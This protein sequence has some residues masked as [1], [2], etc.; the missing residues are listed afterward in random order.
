MAVV[1]GVPK[2]DLRFTYR[3][4]DDYTRLSTATARKV[5]ATIGMLREQGARHPSLHTRKVAGNPDDR[6]HFMNVDDQYRMVAVLQEP[7]VLLHLVGNHDDTLARGAKAT[8]REFEERLSEDP[9]SL[10]PRRRDRLRE[11]VP[12]QG[13]FGDQPPSLQEILAQPEQVA[14]L[15]TGDQ[16]GALAGYRDGTIEDWMVFLSPLQ[17]RALQRTFDGP[18]RVTGGP[19]TGKTVV[20]IHRAGAF[21]AQG[22]GRGRVLMTSFVKNIPETL[23]GLFERFRPDL[24]ERM[25]FRHIHDLALDV[26]RNRDIRVNA[27]WNAAKARFF[28]VFDGQPEDAHRLMRSG[29]GRSYVWQEVTR[30]IEGRGVASL[31]EYLVLA[32]H[33]RKQ[34]MQESS[35]RLVWS[36][37]EEYR[38]ACDERD[39]PLVDPERVLQMALD[40]IRREPTGQRYAAIVVD[41]AQDITEVGIRFLCELLEGGSLGKLLLVGDQSQRIYAGGFRLSETGLETRGRGAALKICYRSTDQIMQVVAALG[42]SLS[43]DDYGDDGLRSFASA[44]VREGTRPTLCGFKTIDEEVRWL[45]SELDGDDDLTSA[46][47]L[48][49]TNPSVDDWVGRLKASGVPHVRLAGYAGRPLPGVKIGT[50]ARAKGLEFKRVFLP[51]LA[52]GRFPW[53]DSSDADAMLLQGSM[54]Y[55]AMSRAR[56]RLDV[57]YSGQPSYFL[58]GLEGLFQREEIGFRPVGGPISKLGEP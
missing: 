54:L 30:V 24:M 33:G 1:F 47:I 23:E 25:A 40:A 16:L 6:F 26:L 29:F 22:Q 57:S 53:G 45:V 58:A 10:V 3:F 34:A 44:T 4:Y 41:E 15:I 56:D 13:L 38:A 49:P 55:V 14:D 35:R 48:V 19:G 27:D 20:A 31:E 46:A 11:A 21:A 9:E 43:V 18:G 37:Y 17:A 5:D 39:P 36:L 2:V 42:R 12:E 28:R 32:R 51:G 52:E 7:I 8:L 50:Y